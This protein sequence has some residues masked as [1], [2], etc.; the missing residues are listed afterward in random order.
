MQLAPPAGSADEALE[1]L[2]T[3]LNAVEDEFTGIPYRPDEW[4]NDGRMYPPQPDSAR[5]VDGRPDLT[6]YRSLGHNTLIGANGAI[7]IQSIREK[8]AE[9]DKSGADGCTIELD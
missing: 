5:D 8:A 2:S 9:L 1:L 6:R 7:L 4:Q 3:T